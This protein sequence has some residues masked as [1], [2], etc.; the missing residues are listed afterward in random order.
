VPEGHTLHRLANALD[1]AFAG[2][3]VAVASP[4]GRFAEAAAL[5]HGRTVDAASAHGKHLFVDVDSGLTWHVHLGLIGKFTLTAAS[6][7]PAADLPRGEVRARISDGVTIGDLRGPAACEV[8]TA[9][10]VSDIV[11]RLGPDPLRADADP[12]MAWVRIH[13]SSRPIAALLMDQAVLSGIGN[14]YRSEVLFR[15]RLNPRRPGNRLARRSWLAIWADLTYL[16]PIGVRTGSIDT[17]RPEH[18][19]AAMGREPRQDDHGGE[20]YVYRRA[21]Q[22]CHV[23][24]SRIR[25]AVLDGRNLF[26]C[27]NCQ[28]RG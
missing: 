11:G 18:E 23:C 24:G 6:G 5:L 12:E 28:R 14:V 1:D 2:R 22:A 19:P 16:M 3:Q 20:V 27:G 26:W 17:V 25:T 10:E 7:D 4:Q 15:N 21:N 13:R 8:L 9:G